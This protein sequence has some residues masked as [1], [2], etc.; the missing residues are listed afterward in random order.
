MSLS[1]RELFAGAGLAGVA[2]LG[3][4][5][6]SSAGEGPKRVDVVVVGAGLSGLM[7]A[8]KLK[9][10]GMKVHILESRGRTGGRMVRKA[11]ESGHFIDLGG[12]WGGQSHHRLRSLV[13]EL[14]LET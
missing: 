13:R 6:S 12:Q 4:H 5:H 9:Q 11:I 1:R 14:G 10:L 2:A 3:L 7:A 8:R